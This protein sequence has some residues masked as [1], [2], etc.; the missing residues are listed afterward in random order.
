MNLVVESMEQY[1]LNWCKK[2][3]YYWKASQI[4]SSKSLKKETTRVAVYENEHNLVLKKLKS[5]VDELYVLNYE[6]SQTKVWTSNLLHQIH[7]M[8]YVHCCGVLCNCFHRS[9]K[10][11]QNISM[12]FFVLSN[13]WS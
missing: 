10:C 5:M 2:T 1:L 7:L 11:E 6:T 13:S 12:L 9:I 4:C 8:Y 3:E